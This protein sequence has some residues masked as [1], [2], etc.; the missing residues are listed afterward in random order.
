MSI[1]KFEK[2]KI[3]APFLGEPLV[4]IVGQD[5]LGLLNTGGR[6]FELLLRGLN[7]VTERIR[8]YSF[9]CWFF[10]SYAKHIQ[11]PNKKIQF[12]HLRRAEF[13]LSLLAAKNGL[14]GIGGITKAL[15]LY[16]KID[17]S[18]DLTIGTGE[19]KVSKDG[20]YWKNPRGIF[21]Q[22]YVSSL[23]Q[24]NLI[25]DFDVD[26]G[27][28]IKTEFDVEGK[29]SG[30][31]L[32]LAFEDNIGSSNAATFI[33][34]MQ[35]GRITQKELEELSIPFDMLNVPIK[36]NEHKLLW[37]LITNTDEPKQDK[38]TL[39]R[40]KTTQLL[41]ETILL[42]EDAFYDYKLTFDAYHYKGKIEEEYEETFS[43]WYYY[44][45]EQFWHMACTGSLA[46]FLKILND[47]SNGNWI[48]EDNLINSIADNVVKYLIE[49]YG[50]LGNESF[51]EIAIIDS[52]EEEIVDDA[53]R[54]TNLFGKL[55]LNIILVR[56]LIHNNSDEIE[57]LLQQTKTYGLNSNSS[58]LTSIASLQSNS[59]LSIKEFIIY[60]IKKYVVIRHQWVSIKKMTIS[61][62][63]EKF[64]REEGLIRFIDD[65]DYA[66][67][68]P[69]LSTLVDFMRDLGIITNDKTNLT[70]HGLELFNA[71]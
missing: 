8:Y 42:D 56:K 1:Q 60:F 34:A 13:I 32:A 51:G 38:V 27:I 46:I 22:N 16:N 9:Y 54:N 48:V 20:T 25:R 50:C 35:N 61:Q 31:Q 36:T 7:N 59:D 11:K 49:E 12:D 4:H 5:P 26:S 52:I 58:F 40:K 3:L 64:I 21:G 2:D 67:S 6:T 47:K 19:D 29:V 62:S 45:L 14:Q 53:K 39:F 18:F 65:I 10:H 15:T 70:E 55:A 63:T 44:Q 24:L 30:N 68:S 69:R 23:K 43:L 41:L 33:N 57:R 28:F 17:S 66:Y 37:Q 71:L